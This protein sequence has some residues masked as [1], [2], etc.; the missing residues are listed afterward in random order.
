MAHLHHHLLSIQVLQHHHTH[1]PPANHGHHV[2]D[3][4]KHLRGIA[5]KCADPKWKLR[6]KMASMVVTFVC[7]MML[8]QTV[9]YK[10]VPSPKCT[11]VYFSPR[12]S[13]AFDVSGFYCDQLTIKKYWDNS[14][15]SHWNTSLYLLNQMPK[16]STVYNFTVSENITLSAN[17]FYKLSFYLYAGSS[18]TIK[19]C[20]VNGANSSDVQVCV[21]GGDNHGIKTYSCEHPHSIINLCSGQESGLYY[22]ATSYSEI[23]KESKIYHFVYSSQNEIKA[24]LQVDMSFSSLEHSIEKTNIFCECTINN[25]I[26]SCTIDIPTHFHGVAA[27]ATSAPLDDPTVWTDTLPVSWEC[28]ASINSLEIYM[29]L[30]A[31]VFAS[32]YFLLLLS[33]LCTARYR[34]AHKI[35]RAKKWIFVIMVITI[36][37]IATCLGLNI[38]GTQNINATFSWSCDPVNSQLQLIFYVPFYIAMGFSIFLMCSIMFVMRRQTGD[39]NTHASTRQAVHQKRD[40]KLRTK[41]ILIISAIVTTLI[42]VPCFAATFTFLEAILPI[43]SVYNVPVKVFTPGDTQILS[44]FKHFF[45]SSLSVDYIGSPHLSA[46]LY[47]SDEEPPLSKYTSYGIFKQFPCNQSECK[48]IWQSYLNPHSSVNIKVCLNESTGANATFSVIKGVNSTFINDDSLIH[49]TIVWSESHQLNSSILTESNQCFEWLSHIDDLNTDRYFFILDEYNYSIVNVDLQFNRTDYSPNYTN[50]S[51]VNSC[52]INSHSI[53][54]CTAYL[55]KSVS[56]SS[57]ALIVVTSDLDKPLYEWQETI[58]VTTSYNHRADTWTI[59]W[60]P[61]FVINIIV[62]SI[63]CP[64]LIILKHKLSIACTAKSKSDSSTAVENEERVSTDGRDP[65]EQTP[66]LQSDSES[67]SQ[68]TYGGPEQNSS[69]AINSSTVTDVPMVEASQSLVMPADKNPDATA[70]T[71]DEHTIYTEGDH[72]TSPVEVLHSTDINSNISDID[73]DQ[74]DFNEEVTLTSTGAVQEDQHNVDT[75]QRDLNEEDTPIASMQADEQDVPT[76]LI[77]KRGKQAS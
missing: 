1:L 22:N 74:R 62:L 63:V 14:P 4:G 48:H 56:G 3:H 16:L 27:V 57:T 61:V 47:V 36:V 67:S 39:Q 42:I 54:T 32:L 73:A 10:A 11:D 43:L 29:F 65:N 44:S 49:D 25:Q 17:D 26:E 28:D 75:E 20:K 9:A 31:A 45:V 8:L 70:N 77:I 53:D 5:E 46:T 7:L 23:I 19:A 21:I 50:A 52:T 58:I 2:S 38:L 15:P 72:T 41:R 55:Q 34:G 68:N 37:V 66:L 12:T 18:Y 69:E 51:K 35:W 40:P 24:S 30:P 76:T 33:L 60:L 6:L 59:V 64:F 13:V 71:D